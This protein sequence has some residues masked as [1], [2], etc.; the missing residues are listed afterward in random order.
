MSTGMKETIQ[1]RT[2]N[3]S[4]S[5]AI[6]A[7]IV[8]PLIAHFMDNGFTDALSNSNLIFTFALI[9]MFLIFITND[10]RQEHDNASS[11]LTTPK[12]VEQ[13]TVRLED[14]M[15]GFADAFKEAREQMKPEIIYVPEGTTYTADSNT[16]GD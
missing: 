9:A 13:L 10:K 3:Q 7:A 8:A 2:T 14:V 6:I 11:A 4:A 16:T 5:W 1:N 12:V 15:H